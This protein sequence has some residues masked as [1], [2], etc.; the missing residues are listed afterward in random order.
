LPF[1]LEPHMD[2]VAEIKQK[3]DIASVIGEYL[4]LKKAGMN[5]RARC[6]FHH[7]KTPSF[8]VSPDRQ[9]F[10][11]FGCGEGGD[12]FSFIQKIEGVEF[13]E[14]LRLLAQK[15]GVTI[16]RFDPRIASQKNRL[17]DVCEEAAKFWQANLKKDIGKKANEYI[18]RRKIKPET[19]L[20]FKIG[21]APDS[22]DATMKHLLAQK[23]NESE[24]FKAGFTV[25]KEN[26][27]SYYDRFR[28]RL[29]FPIL[30]VHGNVIGFSGRT[31]KADE[32]A[33]YINTPESP[34]YHKGKVLYGLDKAKLAIRE[35]GHVIV[36]EGNMD[37]LTAQEAGYRH[38]VACSGTALTTEQIQLLKRYTNNIALC[39]DADEAGQNAA[40]RSIDLLFAAEMNVKIV[41]VKSGKDPDE[42]IKNSLADW[43]ESLRSAKLAMD[44]YLDSYLTAENLQNINKKK[45]AVKNVLTEIAKLADKIEQDHWIKKLA[46]IIN[47][48]SDLLWEALRPTTKK[49]TVQSGGSAFA[50]VMPKSA[51]QS[52]MEKVFTILLNEPKLIPYVVEHLLPEMVTVEKLVTFYT[53]LIS[54]YNKNKPQI[55]AENITKLLEAENQPL[56]PEY[57]DYL[58]L[59]IGKEY[60]G[61]TEVQLR[62]ELIDLVLAIKLDYFNRQIE[63]HR[64]RLEQAS[65][66]GDTAQEQEAQRL[67]Q[68]FSEEKARVQS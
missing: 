1:A 3:L 28:D 54:C 21:Y 13:P 14:A 17:V 57:L 9:S 11:C 52:N 8:F 5:F 55:H 68:W 20:E 40:R 10:H 46:E 43:E 58:I 48:K 53:K 66:A 41:K 24:I 4:E 15:A 27:T 2:T 63:L 50:V 33:K 49:S 25:Q 22:W 35:L 47:V 18:T 65:S 61:F 31:L 29:M 42:C 37:A 30:D 59:L 16:E 23:F 45:L 44:F 12:M 51:V 19:I 60:D 34:I 7:E 67:V 32:Q 26:T 64:Q 6:P 36:V 39:F 62:E 38:T 56:P